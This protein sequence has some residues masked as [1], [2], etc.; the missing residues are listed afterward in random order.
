MRW[1][2]NLFSKK[3]KIELSPDELALSDRMWDG[4]KFFSKGQDCYLNRQPSEALS[5]L[6]RALEYDFEENF[7]HDL[8][9]LYDLRA[10][11][12]QELRY[13]YD[14]INDF[15]KS[16]ILD[17]NDSNKFFSRSTSKGAILDYVGEITDLEEAI[18]LSK[19]NTLLNSEYNDEVRNQGYKNAV[20]MFEMRLR[21]AKNNL[22]ADIR[23]KAQ[24]HNS[25]T[26]ESKE[27]LQ[28]MYDDRR[29]RMLSIIKR[30]S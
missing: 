26:T 13:H 11:C 4:F 22:E 10:A 20:Q 28:K 25:K 14:A 24:I 27:F 19:T 21:T 29:E 8:S 3:T 16:I 7:S 6:D 17:P 9:E 15:D 12:L 1:I 5:Y 23:S 18:Q 2:L 30:R